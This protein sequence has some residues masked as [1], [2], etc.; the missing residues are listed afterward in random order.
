MLPCAEDLGAV[1][2]CVP[3]VLSELG[4]LGLRVLRWTRDWGKDGQPYVPASAYPALSVACPSVHD[5]SSLRGWY[6]GEADKAQ[7]WAFAAAALGKDLGPAPAMLTPEA[8]L[9][10]LEAVAASASAVAVYPLQD[11]LA[12]APA[13]GQGRAVSYRPADPAEERINVPGTT[14]DWNWGWRLPAS[15]EDIAADKGLSAAA[16]ELAAAR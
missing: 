1:P 2:D 16:R 7:V 14:N 9:V 8:A 5:S 12:A 15:L 4:I 10:L 13:G 3:K 6:E 11:I